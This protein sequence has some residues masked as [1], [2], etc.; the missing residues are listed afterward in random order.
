MVYLVKTKGRTN[1]NLPIDFKSS[2]EV[3]STRSLTK[4]FSCS[5]VVGWRNLEASFAFVI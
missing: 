2:G 1:L 4:I 3:L 5:K